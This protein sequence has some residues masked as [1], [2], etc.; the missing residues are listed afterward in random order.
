MCVLMTHK[1]ILVGASILSVLMLMAIF[2]PLC[3]APTLI[4]KLISSKKSSPS[5]EHIFGTDELGR[6]M[7]TRVCVGLRIHLKLG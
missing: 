5:L 2:G 4:K 7:C 1:S 6:D 3:L